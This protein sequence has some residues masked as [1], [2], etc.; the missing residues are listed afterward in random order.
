MTLYLVAKKQIV[1][2]TG[3]NLWYI[4]YLIFKKENM[5]RN[6]EMDAVHKTEPLKEYL[7]QITEK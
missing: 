2:G 3:V 4:Y 7:Y 5:E 6:F 1:I